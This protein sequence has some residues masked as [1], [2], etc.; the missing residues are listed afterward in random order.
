M[1]WQIAGQKRE[2]LERAKK[3]SLVLAIL[4][5]PKS[6]IVVLDKVCDVSSSSC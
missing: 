5:G 1:R 3:R 2:D 4:G 6:V